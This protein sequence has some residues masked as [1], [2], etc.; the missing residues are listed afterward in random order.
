MNVHQ[1]D[2]KSTSLQSLTSNIEDSVMLY[3]ATDQ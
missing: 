3:Q 2:M 1:H